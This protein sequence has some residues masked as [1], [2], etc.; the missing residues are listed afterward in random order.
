MDP[1]CNRGPR[2][3]I[4]AIDG[5]VGELLFPVIE[6]SGQLAALET[7]KRDFLHKG[8]DLYIGFFADREGS[9]I[10]DFLRGVLPE[11]PE[12]AAIYFLSIV[13]SEVL[14]FLCITIL[15]FTA[16]HSFGLID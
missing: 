13:F 5:A 14:T 6:N 15:S 3:G 4:I 9:K 8:L 2:Y 10:H 16:I 1:S 11:R 12:T 7:I